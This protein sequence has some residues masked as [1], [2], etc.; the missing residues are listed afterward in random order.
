MID[1]RMFLGSVAALAANC[2]LAQAPSKVLRVG[3]LSNEKSANAPFFAAF[4]N[5]L[6]DLGYI[7]GGNLVIEAKFG[8]GVTERLDQLAV[9]LVHWKPA[10]IVTQG[11]PAT[12]PVIRAG[13]T[14]PVVF[15]F[16]GDPIE[17]KLVQSLARPGGNMTGMTFLSHELVGKRMELLKEAMPALK[18]AMVMARPQHPGEQ[19]ELRTTQTA[20]NAL[21]VA[22]SYEPVRDEADV[23]KV[24]GNALKLRSEAIVAFPDAGMMRYSEQIAAFSLKHRIPAVSGWAQFADNGN[25]MSYGPNLQDVFHR[26]AIYVEKIHKGA[27]PADLPVELPTSVEMVV[28]MKTAR[29]LGLK[30]P[31]SIML[32]ANKVIE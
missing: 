10:I 4:H 13:A 16:S 24:L 3:W 30:I 29:A 28:N 1:R 12:Y 25:L 9:E 6:R 2:A 19:A 8:E 26:L 14:M 31:N 17:G 5:G 32:R 18:R 7:S 22:I 20:A 21:G 11:G 23:D 15:G 27:K